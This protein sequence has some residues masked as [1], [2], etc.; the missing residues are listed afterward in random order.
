[1]LHGHE[2]SITQIKYSREGDLIYSCAKDAQPNVWYSLNGERLGSFNG[3]NGAVWCIDVDWNTTKVLTGAA[4]NTCKLWDAQTGQCV[5]TLDTNTAVRSCG[6]SF[7]ANYVMLTTDKTMGFPCEILIYD[8]RDGSQLMNGEPLQ[9][10]S[11]PL[12]DAKITSAIWAGL[13]DMILTGHENGDLRQYELKTG[14]MLRSTKGHN[15]QINDI[16]LSKDGMFF[17]TA[18]KDFSAKLFDL[19][20]MDILKTYKT[21]R[22]VN[23]ASISPLFDHVVLGGGQE[24]MSVTTTSTRIGKFDARFFHMIFEEEFGSVKGHFG[25]INSLSF[26]PDGKS[27]SSGGEDGFVRMHYFDQTYLDF[28]F[29]F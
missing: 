21:E 9:K 1:M 11:I 10:I 29:E 26:H 4:D 14:D 25:P 3:H 20:N 22:P 7:S 19:D 28:Q 6:F 5:S 13:D 8:V 27:Y 18:S 16:Q 2:R 15:K 23:S 12:S 24:A 17:I